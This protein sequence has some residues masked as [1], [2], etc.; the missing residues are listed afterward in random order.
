MAHLEILAVWEPKRDRQGVARP[1]HFYESTM[2][3][4][5]GAIETLFF[6]VSGG[7]E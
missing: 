3:Q 6:E 7:E 2:K 4:L 1:L 5:A